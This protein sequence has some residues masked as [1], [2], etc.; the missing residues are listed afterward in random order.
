MSILSTAARQR[1]IPPE[2]LT[3]IART[4]G[5]VAY[6]AQGASLLDRITA[7]KML[8]VGTTGDYA[9]FTIKTG[10]TWSGIDIDLVRNLADSLGAQVVFVPTTWPTLM[11]DLKSGKFDI[12]V[13]GIS[14]TQ[15][16]QREAYQSRS[17]V[18]DGKTPIVR[19]GEE[20][21]YD[22]LDEIN[23]KGVRAIVNPGGTNER[24]AQ[25]KLPAADV[26]VFPDNTR[27]FDEIAAGRA[28]V[29]ITDR[30]EVQWQ[31]AR[32]PKLCAAMPGTFN[33]TEKA[34]VMPRDDAL[35]RYVDSW[36]DRIDADGTL[37]TTLDKYLKKP[38]AAAPAPAVP[39]D[40]DP[41]RKAG[42]SR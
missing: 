22:T 2:T 27:I 31:A 6:A 42:P 24:F 36:F 4:A 35:L 11:Q 7:R 5:T 30:I 15:E 12:A 3:E 8:R 17:Y 9:P 32:N 18:N 34:F 20:A 16:R 41:R 21:K 33:I 40:G 19:C 1:G 25:A 29:M 39:T 38:P 37:K 23:R 13:G 28:D 10:D 26:T 14:K